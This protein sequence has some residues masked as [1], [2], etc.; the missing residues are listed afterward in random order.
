[1][2]A[3]YVA[4]KWE[5]R[6]KAAELMAELKRRGHTITYDWTKH[7]QESEAQAVID[8][9]GVMAADALVV[10]ADQPYEFRGTYTEMG[11]AAARNI[12][13]LLIGTGADRNIFTK[14]PIVRRFPD[15]T[16]LEP[17]FEELSLPLQAFQLGLPAVRP[18]DTTR[19]YEPAVK[20]NPASYFP[21]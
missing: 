9:Q 7:E 21:R 11:V 2:A 14:L 3:I 19:R 10:I 20:R 15:A 8:L 16:N 17:L 1:M 5:V 18:H 13:I 4:T 12:P 6:E